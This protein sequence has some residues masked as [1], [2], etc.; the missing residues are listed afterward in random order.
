MAGRVAAPCPAPL[1]DQDVPV[2][3]HPA[4]ASSARS[5]GGQKGQTLA[6]PQFASPPDRMLAYPPLMGRPRQQCR[7]R[8]A[9]PTADEGAMSTVSRP[10]TPRDARRRRSNRAALRHG[11]QVPE[12]FRTGV[13]SLPSRHSARGLALCRRSPAEGPARSGSQRADE[14][15]CRSSFN[16][17]LRL[18]IEAL[19]SSP[20]SVGTAPTTVDGSDVAG[21]E[22]RPASSD[23]ENVKVERSDLAPLRLLSPQRH[24]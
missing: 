9:N 20:A 1:H 17:S 24:L 15:D 8:G 10:S 12:R 2:S 7:R 23:G 6:R 5:F 22:L 11:K 19:M 16:S 21:A 3:E 4:Q 14:P 18:S 13:V